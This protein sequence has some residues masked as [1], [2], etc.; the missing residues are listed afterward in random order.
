MIGG[1]N[2]VAR[3][4]L[5]PREIVVYVLVAGALAAGVTATRES[6]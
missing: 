1:E 2:A 5:A 6:P 3:V 4:A